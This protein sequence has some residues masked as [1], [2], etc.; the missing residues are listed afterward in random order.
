MVML[1]VLAFACV[2][3]AILYAA[4]AVWVSDRQRKLSL[5]RIATY[6]G[7]PAVAGSRF[8]RGAADRY[9]PPLARL[10]SRLDPRATPDR[11][12]Q[13]LVAA[14]LAR[15]VTPTMFLASKIVFAAVAFGLTALV[16][17]TAGAYGRALLFGTLSGVAG[18]LLPDAVAIAR[19]KTRREEM[20]IALPDALD[21]LAVSVE[22]GLGFDA[23]LAKVGEHMEGPLVDEFGLVLNEMRVGESRTN[24]LRNLGDRSGFTEMQTFSQAVIQAEQHGAPLGRVLRVQA[25]ESRTRRKLA[26]EEKAM[27]A[28]V[29]MLIPT[30]L[31]VFPA[32]FVVILGPALFRIFET[33]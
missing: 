2:A 24:A 4:E 21:V 17:I 5:G 29:K 23:A 19:S 28:P 32:M 1:L 7:L 26:A 10:A 20:K 9:A 33:F 3:G 11:V 22:A 18:F 27:K 31:F 13:R 8:G 6:S 30:G 16:S 25:S 14:G 12:G 15:T